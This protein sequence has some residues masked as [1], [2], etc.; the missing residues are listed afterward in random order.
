M[1]S[2]ISSKLN[3]QLVELEG[4]KAR[5]EHHTDAATVVLDDTQVMVQDLSSLIISFQNNARTMA[6]LA[7]VAASSSS[8]TMDN[9]DTCL[10]QDTQ[11]AQQ[12]RNPEAIIK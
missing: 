3:Y 12:T 6:H 2:L 7:Q 11:A 1:E 8:T 4:A 9:N 5:A 10:V